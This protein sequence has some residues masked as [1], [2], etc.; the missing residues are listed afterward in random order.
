[1]RAPRL[2]TASLLAIACA[3]PAADLPAAAANPQTPVVTATEQAAMTALGDELV[4]G[5]LPDARTASIIV[6]KVAVADPAPEQPVRVDRTNRFSYGSEETKDG[7]RTRTFDG[8]HLAFADGRWL[9]AM[10]QPIA[11]KAGRTITPAESAV[12][13]DAAGLAA[14]LEKRPERAWRR[15][16]DRFLA[17]FKPEARQRL[18]AAIA[19]T[20]VLR[21][22]DGPWAMGPGQ[23]MLHRA[24]VPGADAM[25]LLGGMG[26]VRPA[27][28]PAGE[29]IPPLQLTQDDM[30]WQR[31]MQ[32]LNG[33]KIFDHEQWMRDQ[34]GTRDVPDP[35]PGQRQAVSRWLRLLLLDP[36]GLA[37]LGLDAP[38]AAA[39]AVSVLPAADRQAAQARIDLLLARAGLPEKAPDEADLGVRLQSWDAIEV[40][41][42]QAQHLPDDE[43]IA[44]MPIESQQHYRRLKEA[45][46][47]W[48][49]AE[50]DIPALLALLT[51]ARPSRWLDGEQPRTVG[52]NALR[53]IARVLRFDPRL[54][55][56]REPAMPWTDAER[57]ATAEALRAWWTG[58]GGRQLD[59]ALT[60][61]IAT[62]PA[63]AAARVVV[64]R[65]DEARGP[66][67]ARLVAAWQGK[68][69]PDIR[70]DALAQL[71]STSGG[72]AALSAVV[73]TWP[74]QGELRP[75]LAVWNDQQGRPEALDRL[76]DE[77]TAA[78]NADDRAAS[79][80]AMALRH[81][82]RTPSAA[83][84]QRVATLAAGPLDDRRSWAPLTA[85]NDM[86]GMYQPEWQAV[87]RLQQ[88]GSVRMGGDEV[89]PDRALNLITTCL[90]LADVRPIPAE[91]MTVDRR[92]RWASIRVGGTYLHA[93]LGEKAATQQPEA[94]KRP[95]TGLRVCDVA[96]ATT[97][98][99]AWQVGLHELGRITMDPWSPT[100]ERD[101]VIAKLREPFE[102]RAR[103]AASALKLPDVLPAPKPVDGDK[104]LF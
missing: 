21:R 92:G 30:N 79:S 8:V 74:A 23:L 59:A 81:A 66:M 62:M 58:L 32:L 93:D 44:R 91:Q 60:D 27:W 51:D 36:P 53:A 29:F 19:A 34:A 50:S 26:Q 37:D 94:D 71:L 78:G 18:D 6:G 61:A 11:A 38:R 73:A 75:L 54:L 39:L 82:M 17:M 103:S 35:I 102:E 33:G 14:V 10:N 4:A 98:N 67:L 5:G 64:S 9:M 2:L 24:G 25:I 20:G 42:R 63:A 31:M 55:L 40:D 22:L 104:S 85:M 95:P 99:L 16:E 69:A 28:Q 56:G 65:T 13:V 83:R 12:R 88:N 87:Q 46:S 70:A 57:L 80:L 90:L 7:V 52:D 1:M 72:D 49:P 86:A 76:L 41:P 77:L 97:R 89:A 96:A 15:N 45:M 84:L 100:E 48:K 47:A 101:A 3:L 43:A 68:P